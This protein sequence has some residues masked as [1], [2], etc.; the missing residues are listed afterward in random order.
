MVLRRLTWDSGLSD[1]DVAVGCTLEALESAAHPP[2]TLVWDTA[3]Q[4]FPR[5]PMLVVRCQ[6][7]A[8]GI[9]HLG[10][11]PQPIVQYTTLILTEVADAS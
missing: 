5:N 4:T 8:R 1:T 9:V 11:P 2:L 10:V 7:V 3:E 6:W